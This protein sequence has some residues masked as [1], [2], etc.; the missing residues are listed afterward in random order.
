M[1]RSVPWIVKSPTG[2]TGPNASHSAMAP[3]QGQLVKKWE[4][5]LVHS[6]PWASSKE[7]VLPCLPKLYC[8]CPQIPYC[9]RAQRFWWC[10]VWSFEAVPGRVMLDRT[11]QSKSCLAGFHSPMMSHEFR[12]SYGPISFFFSLPKLHVS[13]FIVSLLQVLY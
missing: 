2:L 9:Y 6:R 4:T 12:Q 11:H 8:P 5:E 3:R 1:K 10:S 7:Q 13:S